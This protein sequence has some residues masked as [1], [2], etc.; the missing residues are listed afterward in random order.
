MQSMPVMARYPCECGLIAEDR[1]FK[2]AKV[3]PMVNLESTIGNDFEIM[4]CAPSG[5]EW[6]GN[7]GWFVLV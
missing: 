6:H 2:I 3:G 4:R 7:R 5:A 1:G